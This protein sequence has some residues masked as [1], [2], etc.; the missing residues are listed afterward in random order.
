MREQPARRCSMLAALTVADHALDRSASGFSP[1][2]S[3]RR[4]PSTRH[5]H[6]GSIPG[7]T[8]SM[9]AAS[10]SDRGINRSGATTRF[11]S[12][13]ASARSAFTRSPVSESCLARPVV[14]QS[15][16]ALR[17]PPA[18]ERAATGVRVPEDCA[19][20]CDQEIARQGNLEA[21]RHCGSA[22]GP[23]D[24]SGERSHRPHRVL[25]RGGGH[26]RRQIRFGTELLQVAP[27][28]EGIARLGEHYDAH[29]GIGLQLRE[30]RRQATAQ[31]TRQRIPGL[32]SIEG[33]Q[34]T[35]FEWTFDP[36]AGRLT[37]VFA[38]HD[39]A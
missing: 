8:D 38:G 21:A 24:R 7:S 17:Q 4:R 33:D 26:R 18:G 25:H 5:L 36:Q 16:Q 1:S 20:R 29:P 28:A 19:G 2:A 35:P 37:C 34:G 12:P 10:F 3:V 31:R 27:R 23:D 15:G 11:T 32:R 39:G 6:A 9:S 22:D 14:D 30:R 13:Q